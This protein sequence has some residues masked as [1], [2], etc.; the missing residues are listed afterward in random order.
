MIVWMESL[1]L[2]YPPDSTLQIEFIE[3]QMVSL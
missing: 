2:G 1:H 3:A